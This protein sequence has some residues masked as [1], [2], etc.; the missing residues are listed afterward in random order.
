MKSKFNTIHLPSIKTRI[1]TLKQVLILLFS[2]TLF[3]FSPSTVVFEKC[4]DGID[5]SGTLRAIEQNQISGNVTGPGGMPLPGVSIV[6]KGSVKGTQTGFDGN[7][8][9]AANKGDI[10]V[11]S[12]LGM[13]TLEIVVADSATLNI[14]MTEDVASLDEVVV[15]GY[16][17]VKKSDLTGSVSSLKGN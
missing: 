10:L 7:F 15:V 3:A 11:F 14:V 1:E 13:K 6:L 12:Y 8:A 4:I 2:T 17:T 16:G 9:I 5:E